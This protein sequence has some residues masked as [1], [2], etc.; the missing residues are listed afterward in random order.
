MKRL[1]SLV[2][3]IDVMSALGVSPEET[4]GAMLGMNGAGPTPGCDCDV[5]MKFSQEEREAALTRATD[6]VSTP[7]EKTFAAGVGGDQQ[8][9][10]LL[11]ELKNATEKLN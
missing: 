5:C 3:V 4:L 11:A 10:D 6:G 2:D 8:F 1:Q 7:K 9:D